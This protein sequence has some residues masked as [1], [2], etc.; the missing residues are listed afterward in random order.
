MAEKRVA[1]IG[2]GLGGLS[3]AI[4]LAHAGFR[5]D[6][7]DQQPLVGGKAGTKHHGK[8]R[9]DTGPSLLTMLPVFE[10]LFREAGQQ[11]ED[12][13]DF[14]PLAPI[15]HYYFPDGTRL[16]SYSEVE[17]FGDEI[18][19]KTLDNRQALERYLTYG[20][21]IY[22]NA[23]ELF[24][25]N[26][27]HELSS[28]LKVFSLRGLLNLGK[29]DAFRSMDA[30]NRSFFR[31]PRIV[32]LFDRYATYNGSSPY[33]VPAT[34][35]IIPYVEHGQGGYAVAGGIY[36]IPAALGKLAEKL[37]VRVI[38]NTRVERILHQN[39]RIRG[40]RVAGES[41]AYDIV[42]SNADVLRTYEDLLEDLQARLARRYQALE[43]SSSGLV[44]FWGMKESFPEL[45]VNNIFFSDDYPREFRELFV[46]RICPED[47]TV[48]VN[49]TSKVTP[50]DAPAEGENW[51]VLVN[52]PCN[53]G[54]DWPGQAAASRE[55][56]LSRLQHALGRAVDGAIAAEEVMTPQDIERNTGS[57]LGSL[58]GIS[59][60][61]S[62]AAFLRHPNRS[63]R[64]RGLYFCGGSVHPG[65]GMPLAI[66]SG[67]IASDLIRRHEG[68]AA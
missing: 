47:P 52:A 15:C 51:F 26:S 25:W 65:G 8:F 6:L 21:R 29:I 32:Q 7:Y 37:G 63:R 61:T 64:Y 20:R 33:Q 18:E 1:V 16:F 50:E 46:E 23:A 14:I 38:L 55:R 53:V 36:A 34:L 49:I 57:R 39:R 54:Q 67:K 42:V 2:A 56:I 44:F 12:H 9:F 28:Y 3:A 35:N 58:Y 17:R 19:A 59:S 31:D 66:L 4:R 30:A 5:V 41:L 68:G 10:Q 60:N 62:M 27:L 43:P 24:L 45:G 40:I 13:L 11:L 22:E 48:Y